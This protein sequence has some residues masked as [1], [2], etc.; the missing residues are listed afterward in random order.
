MPAAAPTKQ[1]FINFM[2]RA[3]AAFWAKLSIPSNMVKWVQQLGLPYKLGAQRSRYEQVAAPPGSLPAFFFPIW[4]WDRCSIHG[5]KGGASLEGVLN[6]VGLPKAEFFD[7]PTRSGS[8][9][10]RVIEH[11]HARLVSAFE[12]WFARDP[13]PYST[14]YYKA[15]L[16]QLF[17]T[18]PQVASPAVIEAAVRTLPA[19][20]AQVALQ[21][22]GEVSKL[23]R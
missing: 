18:C 11:V 12:T 21:N 8:D 6:A 10:H 17:Y 4:S 15:V 19:V 22:G 7:L 23:Y 20:L 5:G 1:E 14:Q 13:Q 16:A 2:R 3:Q 9:M